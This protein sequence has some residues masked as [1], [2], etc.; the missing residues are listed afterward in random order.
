MLKI[1]GSGEVQIDTIPEKYAGGENS[2]REWCM[3]VLENVRRTKVQADLK[4]G[5]NTITISPLSPGFV[6]EKLIL[7]LP[8]KEL[9]G[10]RL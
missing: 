2:C 9:P 8:E 4:K 6:L 7:V 10:S 5:E 3:A 1:N